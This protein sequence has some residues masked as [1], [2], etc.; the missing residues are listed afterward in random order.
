VPSEYRKSSRADP[1]DASIRNLRKALASK[2]YHPPRPWRSKEEAQMIRQFVFQWFTCRDRNRPSGRAWARALGISHTWRQKL[3]R[4]FTED[5]SEMR[6]LQAYGDPTLE[7][8][9]RAQEY[10]REMK[11]RGELR[12]ELRRSNKRQKPQTH[13]PEVAKRRSLVKANPDVSAEEMCEIFD[14]QHV[15][16]TLKIAVSGFRTWP[17]AYRHPYY[18][19]RI[20]LLIKKEARR[21]SK[22]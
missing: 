8:L 19:K 20:Q 2:R 9:S 7:Q 18:R 6:R 3:V 16:L 10:T 22:V 13:D 1:Y 15:P 21:E 11:E 5:P 14:R 17:E 12:G 4:E